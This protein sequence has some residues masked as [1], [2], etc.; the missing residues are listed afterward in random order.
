M[1]SDGEFLAISAVTGLTMRIALS[2]AYLILLGLALWQGVSRRMYMQLALF[3]APFLGYVWLSMIWGG[4]SGGVF[5]RTLNFTLM[6]LT[7]AA[8]ASTPKIRDMFYDVAYG[9]CVLVSA[10]GLA[11]YFS[12]SD[13]AFF[14]NGYGRMY[15]GITVHKGQISTISAI[16]FL[17]AWVRMTNGRHWTPYLPPL[18]ICAVSLFL[19]ATLSS[20]FGVLV[21]IAGLL[22]FRATLFSVSIFSVLLPFV[23]VFFA[24]FFELVGKDPTIT[25]RA[26]LWSFALSEARNSLVLGHGFEHLSALPDW[27]AMLKH[28]FRNDSFFI[29]H[30]HNLWVQSIYQFGVIGTVLLFYTLV[31]RIV[32]VSYPRTLAVQADKALLL[33][34]AVTAGLTLPFL[35]T[36]T[37]G[38]FLTF[39]LCHIVTSKHPAEPKPNT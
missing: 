36:G 8:F 32:S 27:V 12:G 26:F 17:L 16:G 18:V 20:M 6:I 15:T 33:F 4:F 19:S 7:I 9:F 28:Q 38:F 10:A 39:A 24:Y 14:S 22:M 13:F 2:L 30:A 37:E 21:G 25:G 29:P 11:L 31:L 35:Q 34:F 23:Y 5:L 1:A 3:W